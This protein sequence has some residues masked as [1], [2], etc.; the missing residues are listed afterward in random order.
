MSLPIPILK[1]TAG[2]VIF[3]CHYPDKLLCVERASLAKR[4]YRGI[5]D[6]IEEKTTGM[7]H[8]I[9]VNSNFTKHVFSENFPILN[10]RGIKPR[11]V[12]PAIDESVF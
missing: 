10:R 11:V 4:L 2:K 5:L 9:L 12:Y 1:L 6:P 3:Y 8:E 7:A